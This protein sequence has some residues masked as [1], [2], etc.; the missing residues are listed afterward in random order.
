MTN[1]FASRA[2]CTCLA[3]ALPIVLVSAPANAARQPAV[4]TY[5]LPKT[6]VSA[7]VSQQLMSCPSPDD[8]EVVVATGWTLK[9][10][11]KADYSLPIQ[12]DASSGLLTKR[13]V[14]LK[15]NPDGTINAFNSESAG[16]GGAV[17]SSLLKLVGTVAPMIS[18]LGTSANFE[19]SS[20]RGGNKKKRP[21]PCTKAARDLLET[22]DLIEGT[23]ARLEEAVAAGDATPAQVR[24]LTA[25]QEALA[26]VNAKL[27]LS[28][29]EPV[30]FDPGIGPQFLNL[31]KLDYSP[32]F[33]TKSPPVKIVGS[34]AGFC[35]EWAASKAAIQSLKDGDGTAFSR[36]AAQRMYYRRPVPA[37]L[38]AGPAQQGF[39]TGSCS[40]DESAE[41]GA[42]TDALSF[43]APQLSGFYS[44]PIGS[45]GLFSSREVQASFDPSGAPLELSFGSDPGATAIAGTIDAVGAT[46]TALHNAE[47]DAL[48][49]EIAVREKRKELAA[50]RSE[51]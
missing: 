22:R 10:I 4:L 25:R 27:T 28:G 8:G 44:V 51:P 36:V 11:T 5:F 30:K 24:L 21:S 50:L 7:S 2:H 16:Q 9:A 15:L 41:G 3:L 32:W 6:I 23:I 17:I 40:F 20:W 34:D 49:H 33:G 37:L 45:G 12:V 47:L 39:E 29:K 13:S 26:E 18:P 46:A 31:E 38:V 42:A 14:A 35:A 48:T 19:N 43:S 1:L